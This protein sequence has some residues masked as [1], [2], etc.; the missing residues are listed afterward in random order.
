MA[1]PF[2]P[3][4]A[5]MRELKDLGGAIGLLTWDQ[6]TYLPRKGEQARAD[7]LATLQAIHHER[8]VDPKLGELLD[9]ANARAD[10]A[11]DARAMVRVL[12]WERDRAT[13][14]PESLVRELAQAQSRGLAGWRAARE[15]RAFGPFEKPLARLLELRRAEA[16]AFGHADGERYDALL[17]GYEPGMRVA[18]LTGVLDSLASKLAPIAHALCERP[19]PKDWLEGDF[20]PDNQWRF[21]ERML[22]DMGFDVE[23]GRLDKSVHPFTGGAHPTDVRLTTRIDPGH[24]RQALYGTVHECG[25]GLYEQGFDPAHH[26]TPLSSAP[27]MG[28]HE[29]QSRLW[30]NLV[31]RGRP[32]WRYYFPKLQAEFPGPLAGADAEGVY[33][34]TNRVVRSV[35]RVDADEVTYNL[36]IVL[37]YQL[38]LLLVRDELPLSELP[39]EWNR[40]SESLL[41][42]RPKDDVEGVLQDIHW[43]WGELGYFP[44]YALGNLYAAS[45]FAAAH[46]ELPDLDEALG[47]GELRVL[48]D[49]L[50]RRIHGEG[51]R[52][53][54]ED[55]VK[56]VTGG[57]LSDLDFLAHVKAKYGEIYGV[58]L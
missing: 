41:G 29:S 28:L 30:E 12:R 20:P 14:V 23:A 49:W 31:A 16:D 39:Q 18:R 54:A 32:F 56:R 46:R 24:F 8:L 34:A 38:E 1:D 58:A 51:H 3:L 4:L 22:A 15:A 47:R 57:G 36:H 11:E 9:T 21:C 33:R 52:Y 19:P 37:R 26:R 35:I 17:E 50:R 7:H 43:A 48:R 53:A 13:K 42:V 2:E 25:H 5:R 27:S 44:T 10:L 40:R 45:F 6:E 55:L